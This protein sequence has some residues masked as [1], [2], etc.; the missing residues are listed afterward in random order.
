MRSGSLFLILS[1]LRL[2]IR[3]TP[4]M[5]SP[6]PMKGKQKYGTQKK[7]ATPVIHAIAIN[8]VQIGRQTHAFSFTRSA[9]NNVDSH[10]SQIPPATRATPLSAS[11]PK[12][13][14]MLTIM[15]L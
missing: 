8:E 3:L 6:I 12:K 2:M 4:A 11:L 9:G 15:R 1:A 13:T 5:I 7:Y 14:L 10:S